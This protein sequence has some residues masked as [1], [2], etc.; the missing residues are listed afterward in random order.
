MLTRN[1]FNTALKPLTL[2]VFILILTIAF[3]SCENDSEPQMKEPTIASF[4]PLSGKE[5]TVVTITG[6]NFDTALAG[7]EVRFNGV[8]ATPIVVTATYITVPVPEGASTGKISIRSKGTTVVS[9][10]DFV[11]M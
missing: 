8:I 1:H 3:A 6:T 7:I 5:E 2:I 4:S 11:V 10:V 9:S